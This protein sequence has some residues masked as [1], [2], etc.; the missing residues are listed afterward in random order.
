[1]LCGD[2]NEILKPEEKIG[3][4]AREPWSM[5]DFNLMTKVCRLQDLPFSG[6]NMTW[7]GNR[8]GHKVQSWL[9]R[10]FGMMNS[11]RCILLHVLSIWR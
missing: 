5:M 3:G 4:P 9:D 10:G 2:F 6:N 8:K 1:M 7:A 11:E